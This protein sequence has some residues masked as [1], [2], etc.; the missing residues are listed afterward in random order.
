MHQKAE[1]D[2]EEDD[3]QQLLAPEKK[4]IKTEFISSRRDEKK[5]VHTGFAFSGEEGHVP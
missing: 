1:I 3:N 5:D 4:I 2:V